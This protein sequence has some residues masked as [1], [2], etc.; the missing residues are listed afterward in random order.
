MI[1][2][3]DKI[4]SQLTTT[5]AITTHLEPNVSAHGFAVGYYWFITRPIPAV[6]FDASCNIKER[7]SELLYLTK[8]KVL[9][10]SSPE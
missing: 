5:P 7:V 8:L 3:D 1:L 4:V 10:S 2:D 6:Q 9:L